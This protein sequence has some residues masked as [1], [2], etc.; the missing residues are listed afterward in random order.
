MDGMIKSLYL[1]LVTRR[2]RDVFIFSPK[3]LEPAFP[4]MHLDS[5]GG[6]ST[7]GRPLQA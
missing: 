1:D 4:M 6:E 2:N 7:G 5:V 3:T